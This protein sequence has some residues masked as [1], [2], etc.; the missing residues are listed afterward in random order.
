MDYQAI[1]FDFDGVIVDSEPIH[2][3]CWKEVLA[4]LRIDFSWEYYHAHFIGISDKKM[5]EEL[6]AMAQPAVSAETIFGRYD[7]KSELFRE[8]MRQRL[9]F[10]PGIIDF[11]TSA[12]VP[13][14]VVTSSRRE[15][16][17]PVLYAGGILRSLSVAV[18]AEDVTRHKP[19][20]EP[21]RTAAARLGVGKALVVEDSLAGETS[22]RAAGF[23]VVRI[24][25]P[26]ETVRLVRAHLSL[27]GNGNSL[28]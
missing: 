23:D 16:V 28:R 8:R 19:D 17:E 10:A 20:P 18:F 9:P 15:E 11:V 1:L 3:D 24:P 13:V 5:A 4:P 7:A 6:S 21:Y 12:K 25:H 27:A 2:F 22:G 26:D 14:G